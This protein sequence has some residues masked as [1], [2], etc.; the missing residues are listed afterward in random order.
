M[1]IDMARMLL[2]TWAQC[3]CGWKGNEWIG[4]GSSEKCA[5][6]EGMTHALS[7][8]SMHTVEIEQRQTVDGEP[9]PEDAR[10]ATFMRPIV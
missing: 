8:D 3:S 4:I 6:Q 1:S 7:Q 9:V 5:A 10:M 2:K